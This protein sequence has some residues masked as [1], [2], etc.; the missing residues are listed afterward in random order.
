[1]QTHFSAAEL[2]TFKA[3]GLPGSVRRIQLRAVEAGWRG[4]ARTGQGPGV[5]YPLEAL[6]TEAQSHIRAILG[7]LTPLETATNAAFTEP[8]AHDLANVRWENA[9]RERQ[10]AET[11]LQGAVYLAPKEER[12]VMAKL[13]I[14]RAL[15]E[16]ARCQNPPIPATHATYLFTIAY[17]A[18]TVPIDPVAREEYPSVHPASLSRW[19]KS[20]REDGLASLRG[21]Y[22]GQKGN[23]TIET[24]PDLRDFIVA[25]L[26]HAP[27]VRASNLMKQLDAR[28]AGRMDIRLPG[29]RALERW[30]TAWKKTNAQQHAFNTNPDAW[31]NK[32]QVAFGS[33]TEDITYPNQVWQMDGSPA[34]VMFT[35]GRYAL[36]SC[37]DVFTR[38]M[39]LLVTKTAKAEAVGLTLRKAILDWG[40]PTK[41]KTDNGSDYKSR[42]VHMFLAALDIQQEFSPPYTPENKGVVERGFG[43]FTREVSE[44]LDGYIGHSV[45]DRKNIEARKGFAERLKNKDEVIPMKLTGAEFQAICDEWVEHEYHQ[46]AHR[47]LNGRSPIQVA[48]EWA[49][50]IRRI[51]D[52]RALDMLL[53]P[54]KG[55]GM[56]TVTKQGLRVENEL[57]YSDDLFPF[58]G[59]QVQVRMDP[60]D[61]GR[62][63]VYGGP[64]MEFLTVAV[65]ADLLGVPRAEFAAHA[66]A[67]QALAMR[68]GRAHGKK[69][70]R[71]MK[72]S[73]I[74][75]EVRASWKKRSQI[76]QF[77]GASV[78]HDTPELRAA[79]A[80]ADALIAFSTPPPSEPEQDPAA[81]AAF[82]ADFD[83]ER[84]RIIDLEEPLERYIR[85]H[86][87]VKGGGEAS[88]DEARFMR[89]FETTREYRGWLLVHQA[90]A[91]QEQA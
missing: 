47:G 62:V 38:R 72:S 43:T 7:N 69:L 23:G 78:E 15:D 74:A 29:S 67:K 48:A 50:P 10:A 84:Q 5:E 46:R 32:F 75:G 31:K 27:H 8:S 14:L 53:A 26:H 85:L 66:K 21:N 3:P 22:K 2:A 19:R 30:V 81:R 39:K 11:G 18:G 82:L 49:G 24:Q 34:D 58:V 68:E 89:N 88:D 52:E 71:S 40:V 42:H 25:M 87:R 70:V 20:L 86:R 59:Q 73:E 1:M 55:D 28:F 54:A 37:I 90:P 41:V 44:I 91:E 12:R 83:L 35:D 77:P 33:S 57:F 4:R 64:A 60:S 17:T 80:A 63:L 61:M 6:P 36:V 9:E 51:I 65:C 13:H 16:F 76:R 79:G 56:R 45:A